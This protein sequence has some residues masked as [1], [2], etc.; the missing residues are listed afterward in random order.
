MR[1]VN[2]VVQPSE[3][4]MRVS[5]AVDM[6]EAQALQLPVRKEPA[7]QSMDGGKG[8]GVLHAQ[9]RKAVDVEEA[10]V[11]DLA[12]GQLPMGEAVILPLEQAMQMEHCCASACCRAIGLEPALD[13]R[14]GAVDRGE[15]RL[16]SGGGVVRGIAW[17]AIARR[18]FE[19][20][21]A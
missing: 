6:V 4:L 20:L 1:F 11:I 8:G 16:E 12:A 15:R 5:Q 7:H 21:P 2:E 3:I 14:R 17:T 13:D 18:Q 10:P 19:E 9:A